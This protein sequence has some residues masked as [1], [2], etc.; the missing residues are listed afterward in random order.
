MQHLHA[1]YETPRPTC[2]KR[3]A[4]LEGRVSRPWPW[5]GPAAS[6]FAVQKP[7][8][9]RRQHCERPGAYG[10]TWKPVRKTLKDQGIECG[11]SMLP[12]PRASAAPPTGARAP[13]TPRHC[14]P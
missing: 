11:S 6:A 3:V 12:I 13:I 14:Q 4:A 1:D 5:L 10:G 2:W 8:A 7:G 9:D